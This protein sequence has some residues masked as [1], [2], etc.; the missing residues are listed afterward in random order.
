MPSPL[1]RDA[2]D[3]IGSIAAGAQS[4]EE[5]VGEG[6]RL[7]DFLCPFQLI[8]SDRLERLGAE[9]ARERVRWVAALWYV[10]LCYMCPRFSDAMFAFQG[11]LGPFNISNTLDSVTFT[12]AFYLLRAFYSVTY[13]NRLAVNDVHRPTS[14]RNTAFYTITQFINALDVFP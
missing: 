4:A 8:Y 11:R 14:H 7:A 2:I 3:D 1:H 13:L 12:C 9:N 5:D 6:E 10:L